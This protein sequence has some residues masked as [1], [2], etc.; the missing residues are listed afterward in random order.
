M[1]ANATLEVSLNIHGWLVAEIALLRRILKKLGNDFGGETFGIK[2][3]G[4]N[5]AESHAK[6]SG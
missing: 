5:A 1:P 3:V 4:Q 2:T 6:T